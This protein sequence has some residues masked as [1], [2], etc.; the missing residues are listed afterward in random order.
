MNSNRAEYAAELRRAHGCNC[1]QAV[2]VALAD[3]TKLPEELIKQIASGFG[4]GMGTTEATCGA[5][6]GAGIIAGL[7]D[8]GVATL[9]DT[10]QILK[11]FQKLSGAVI[12]KELKGIETGKV[13]CACE[14]CVKNAVHAYET[15]MAQKQ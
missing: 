1:C 13:L 2:A 5:L 6:V 14:D 15:V 8:E 4:G 7:K 11:E 10:K 3:E 9:K 12:C